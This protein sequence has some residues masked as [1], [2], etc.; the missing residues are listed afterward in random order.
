MQ[1]QT[2]RKSSS[3]TDETP[4]KGRKLRRIQ[5]RITAEM[6]SW[7]AEKALANNSSIAYVVRKMIRD[8]MRREAAS[9]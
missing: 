5:I 4:H 8:V 2:P 1:A 7:L 3:R 6:Y 9:A